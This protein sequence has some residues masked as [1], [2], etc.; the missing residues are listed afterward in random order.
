MQLII[1]SDIELD[2]LQL[3]NLL[4]ILSINLH[5]ARIMWKAKIRYCLYSFGP[6]LKGNRETNYN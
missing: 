4:L 2:R 3:F 5:K 6:M 1:H